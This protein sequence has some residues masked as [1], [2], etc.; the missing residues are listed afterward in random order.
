MLDQFLDWQTQ[1]SDFLICSLTICLF[2]LGSFLP[3]ET[4]A[5]SFRR[6]GETW[7]G[8]GWVGSSHILTPALLNS[9]PPNRGVGR[10]GWEGGTWHLCP[11]AVWGHTPVS[12][13]VT[14][15][16]WYHV[17]LI[18]SCD[19]A[20]TQELDFQ[21]WNAPALPRVHCAIRDLSVSQCLHWQNAN[22]NSRDLVGLLE[23][24]AEH[25]LAHGRQSVNF[26]CWYCPHLCHNLVQC[27]WELTLKAG[28]SL[29]PSVGPTELPYQPWEVHPPG[30]GASS[31]VQGMS[32]TGGTWG[33][34]LC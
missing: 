19:G 20:S 13:R 24:S 31:R 2:V 34:S 4:R 16:Q 15:E 12:S 21:G 28:T 29:R 25:Q 27:S 8:E 14:R 33:K 10:T 3:P 26:A 11:L 22:S 18:Q 7:G 30:V 6:K 1:V 32:Q 5:H 17:W 9:S 23:D